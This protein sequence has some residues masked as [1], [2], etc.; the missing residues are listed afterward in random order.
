MEAFELFKAKCDQIDLIL[1]DVV[2]PQLSGPEAYSKIAEL[3][4]GAKVIFTTGYTSEAA[5]LMS[6]LE[7]GATVLQKPF[8]MTSLSQTVRSALDRVQSAEKVQIS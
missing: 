6:L 2:M 4:P 3:R 7:K 5:A 8:G 1:M